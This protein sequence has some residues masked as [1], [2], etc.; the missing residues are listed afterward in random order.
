MEKITGRKGVVARDLTAE[1]IEE[2]KKTGRCPFCKDEC[3]S[4]CCS[5]S[6]V[7]EFYLDDEGKIEWGDT[8]GLDN[9]EDVEC[10]NCD[11]AIPSEIWRAWIER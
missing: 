2:A 3:K 4:F 1:E 9:V 8:Q 6:A 10:K 7:Q 11:E 5:V